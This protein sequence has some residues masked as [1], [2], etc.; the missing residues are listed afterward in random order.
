MWELEELQNTQAKFE[1]E[2]AEV[3]VLISSVTKEFYNT[4]NRIV[5]LMSVK[6]ASSLSLETV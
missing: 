2:E 1:V 5:I 6:N 3:S 4:F